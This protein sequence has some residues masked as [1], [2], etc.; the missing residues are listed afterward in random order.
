MTLY[1]I[2]IEPTSNFATALKGDTL[3]GQLCWLIL[4][5]FGKNRLKSLLEN[6]DNKPF[7]IV[8]DAF[9]SNHLPKP[10]MPS[11]Y[12]SED[13]NDK[14]VNR[15]KIW[16][17][18]ED[19][20]NGNYSKAKKNDEICNK[21]KTETVIRNSINYK[22][23]TT[24]SDKNDGFDP[25]GVMETSLSKK[26]I[27][28]LLDEDRLLKDELETLFINIG[29]LGFGKDANIGKG[30]F[31]VK[32]IKATNFDYQSNSYMT[33]SPFCASDLEC[34]KIFYNPFVRFGKHGGSHANGNAFKKPLLLADTAGVIQFK[35]DSKR[36]FIGKGI[37]GHSR[38]NADTVHQ[39]YAIVVPIKELKAC[40][41]QYKEPD[42]E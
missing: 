14:K 23:F 34:E 39:G 4:Y 33:L 5:S 9:A 41:K 16:L 32:N 27:F 17:K 18:L 7:M 29:K 36:L 12:L 6:Y 28:V 30:R 8:S 13:A 31:T 1:K 26:D 40:K 35:D 20:Q 38:T 42:C 10:V 25:Y 37:K 24:S 19:L 15:K 2:S 22:T 21:D 3:F 11:S